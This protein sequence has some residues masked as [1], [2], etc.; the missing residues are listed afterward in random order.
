MKRTQLLIGL[1]PLL[2]AVG[3]TRYT[4]TGDQIAKIYVAGNLLFRSNPATRHIDIFDLTNPATL[5]RK[6][7]ISI[8]GN[9]DIAVV[10]DVLYADHFNDLVIYDISNVWDPRP[11]DTIRSVFQQTTGWVRMPVDNQ[12]PME[13]H[14]FSG[15]GCAQENVVSAP[16]TSGGDYGGSGQAGSMSR[17]AIVG[18]HLYCVDAS[19]LVVFDISQPARPQLKNS[20][21]LGWQIETIFPMGNKLFVGGQNGMYIVDASDPDA[22]YPLSQFQHGRACDPVVAEDNRAYVTLRN[23][24]PCGPTDNEML[25][26]DVSNLR[27]PVLLGR[28]PLT[29]PY[30]LAVR[31]RLIY[32]C[33]G[34][35]GLKVIDGSNP[36]AVPAP[37]KV[38]SGL[39][40]YDAI[41]RGT[42]LIVTAQD[43]VHI[44][45]VSNAT[46]PVE[47]SALAHDD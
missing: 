21:P 22:P 31:N 5:G 24:S 46:N 41:L 37:L 9:N 42:I 6:A 47:V 2:L 28:V 19:N 39:T 25:I 16:Q 11:L 18:D 1:L 15:C 3:F 34:T 4:S 17:F 36:T 35:G 10:G 45:D 12:V 30:G 13:S 29:N 27:N 7:R 44:F 40:P 8:E 38:I 26:I 20:A 14:G 23:G 43:R 32:L 33:D